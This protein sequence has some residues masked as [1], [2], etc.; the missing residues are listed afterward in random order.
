MLKRVEFSVFFLALRNTLI[1][2]QCFFF[3]NFHFILKLFLLLIYF[4]LYSMSPHSQYRPGKGPAWTEVYMGQV[5]SASCFYMVRVRTQPSVSNK[6]ADA[7]ILDHFT[8]MIPT[9]AKNTHTQT[10]TTL[11]FNTK[12]QT[13][14]ILEKMAKKQMPNFRHPRTFLIVLTHPFHDLGK[15]QRP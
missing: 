1:H 7:N 13:L 2:C 5:Y 14:Q 11:I 8:L 10:L 15:L 6:M 9:T 12:A 3:F 4:Y